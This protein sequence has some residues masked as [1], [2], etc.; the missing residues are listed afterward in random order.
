LGFEEALWD[1]SGE[2]KRRIRKYQKNGEFLFYSP[3]ATSRMHGTVYLLYHVGIGI[4]VGVPGPTFL[5]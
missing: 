5:R 4:R 2:K 1:P 3:D